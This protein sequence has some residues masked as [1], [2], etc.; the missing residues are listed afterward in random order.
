L[1]SDEDDEHASFTKHNEGDW[2]IVMYDGMPFIGCVQSW[3]SILGY[4]VKTMDGN[5]KGT[6]SFTW[7]S[8]QIFYKEEQVLSKI[9]A[10]KPVQQ[11]WP[12]PAY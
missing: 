12:I 2:I 3:D 6:N 5:K 1:D 4:Q 11:P 9:E 10:P 8:W 7:S